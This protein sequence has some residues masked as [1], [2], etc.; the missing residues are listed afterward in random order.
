MEIKNVEFE[1]KRP[2]SEDIVTIHTEYGVYP[3]LASEVERL[4]VENGD[5]CE[6]CLDEGTVTEGEFDDIRDV[7]CHCQYDE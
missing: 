4:L 3:I 2:H 7:P 5:I 1:K 6:D